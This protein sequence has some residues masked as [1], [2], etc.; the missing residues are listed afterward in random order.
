MDLKTNYLGLTLNSPLVAGASPI[1][2]DINN[3]KKLEDCGAGAVVLY[4]LFEEQLRH[5]QYELHYATTENTYASPEAST[6]FPEYDEYRV[7]PEQYLELIRKAKEA[8]NIP[9]IASLNGVTPG[10]WT[11]FAKQMEQAGADAIELNNYSLPTNFYTP[12]V[13]VENLFLEIIDEI[14]SN[15]QIPI[16]VK[17]SP[18]F[19]N[20]AYAAKRFEEAGV[21]GLVLF[22]RFYQPDI[23]LEELEIKPKVQLST[24][25]DLRLALTWIGILKGRITPDLAGSG[26]VHSGEDVIKLMM[27][28]ANVSMIVSALLVNGIDYL[29]IIKKQ[30]IEWMEKKEYVSIMQMQ[31]AMSQ[32][33]IP[34]P[35]AFERAQ[36]M[37]ALTSYQFVKK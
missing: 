12:S 11:E 10:G 22:N 17:L 6:Y 35:S 5:E 31:G 25:N 3:I 2:D 1:S 36:Y 9:I 23:D 27:A 15:I 21:N 28:G 19:T 26:G 37:K 30:I 29:K 13:E 20:M 34:D 7:G 4:S 14:K 18:F 33:N 8:V 16:S 24:S 32:Q